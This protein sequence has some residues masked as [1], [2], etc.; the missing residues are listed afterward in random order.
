MPETNGTPDADDPRDDAS[1]DARHD[2]GPDPGDTD[3]PTGQTQAAVNT[4]NEPAG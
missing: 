3:H 4:E 1:N 2:H